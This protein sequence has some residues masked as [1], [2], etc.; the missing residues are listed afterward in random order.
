MQ[1]QPIVPLPVIQLPS[2]PKKSVA[3]VVHGQGFAK[4][5]KAVQ[6]KTTFSRPFPAKKRTLKPEDRKRTT[7]LRSVSTP[8]SVVRLRLR[9]ISMI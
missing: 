7:Q 3:Q 9:D 5:S 4:L 1:L 8:G 6:P 2:C